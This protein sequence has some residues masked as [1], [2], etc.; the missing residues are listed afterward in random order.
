MSTTVGV[1]GLCLALS[2]RGCSGARL[3]AAGTAGRS[4][5]RQCIERGG[6]CLWFEF[7]C[8]YS[9]VF[10]GSGGPLL[11]WVSGF[12]EGR[13]CLRVS[14][15]AVSLHECDAVLGAALLCVPPHKRKPFERFTTVSWSSS[16]N[17]YLIPGVPWLSPKATPVPYWG[18]THWGWSC[19][20]LDCYKCQ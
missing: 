5:C 13:F 15:R 19:A 12:L 4:T 6:F 3:T 20:P 1:Q 16:C 14:W 7:S 2:C 11:F 17:N 10:C 18:K 8:L 9:L